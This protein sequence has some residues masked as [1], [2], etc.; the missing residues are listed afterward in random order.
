MTDRYDQAKEES[1]VSYCFDL[2]DLG[3]NYRTG[4]AR[5]K[6][7]TLALLW[8]LGRFALGPAGDTAEEAEEVALAL[9]EE[10]DEGTV[11]KGALLRAAN[12]IARRARSACTALT[13]TVVEAGYHAAL[14]CI[15]GPTW[16]AKSVGDS[17]DGDSPVDGGTAGKGKS[18]RKS[19]KSENAIEFLLRF[20]AF[21]HKTAD[22]ADEDTFGGCEGEGEPTPADTRT[23]ERQTAQ[24]AQ[25]RECLEFTHEAMQKTPKEGARC[26]AS[27]AS[28][29]AEGPVPRRTL[30]RVL[31]RTESNLRVSKKTAEMVNERR[32]SEQALAQALANG[33]RPARVYGWLRKLNSGQACAAAPHAHR[34][35]IPPTSS[36]VTRVGRARG[37]SAWGW[38][39]WGSQ[40]PSTE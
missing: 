25:L 10:E 40:G 36:F 1:R 12:R 35:P 15:A 28:L 18:A 23:A 37:T 11:G 21:L 6:L 29:L 8:Q 7:N 26:A 4:R 14:F 22:P 30:S 5:D 3:V 38:G 2:Y 39:V 16:G 24:F 31:S 32:K 17:R 9:A 20:K 27:P 33:G 34:P 19:V 13:A